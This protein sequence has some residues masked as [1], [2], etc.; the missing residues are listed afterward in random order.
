MLHDLKL[1]KRTHN[2]IDLVLDNYHH[3]RHRTWNDKDVSRPKQEQKFPQQQFIYGQ[4]H[5]PALNTDTQPV[6]K[7][8]T[9]CPVTNHPFL[10]DLPRENEIELWNN[11]KKRSQSS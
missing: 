5:A 3:K 7:Y 8:F 2:D 6:W 11:I 1:M 4:T 10:I 9:L